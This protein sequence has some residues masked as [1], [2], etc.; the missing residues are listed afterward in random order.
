MVQ[1][2]L[3]PDQHRVFYFGTQNNL[4]PLSYA[5]TINVIITYI[6]ATQIK[7]PASNVNILNTSMAGLLFQALALSRN[8]PPVVHDGWV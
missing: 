2:R 1:E 7:P 4:N 6:P 5:R 3:R 8:M